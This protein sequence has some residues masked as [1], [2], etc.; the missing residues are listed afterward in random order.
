MADSRVTCEVRDAVATVT[1][2]RPPVNALTA[3]VVA[4]TPSFEIG[5]SVVYQPPRTMR[6]LLAPTFTKSVRCPPS[7][8]Y[9]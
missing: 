2:D 6:P 9:S 4:K 8:V 1:V 3:A 7:L 5:R